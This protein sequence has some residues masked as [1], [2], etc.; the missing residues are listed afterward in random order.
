MALKPDFTQITKKLDIQGLVSSVKSMINPEGDTPKP[1]NGDA[2]GE[3]MAALSMLLQN[4]AAALTE[5]GNQLA[6]ANQLLNALFKDLETIR[7]QMAKPA[8]VNQDKVE[9]TTATNEGMPEAKV[10]GSPAKDDPNNPGAT[11]K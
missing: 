11:N 7:A 9:Q 4:T 3:K 2:L 10:E 1:V 8:P 6:Q 5:Q